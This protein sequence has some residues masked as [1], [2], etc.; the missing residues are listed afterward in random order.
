MLWLTSIVSSVGTAGIIAFIAFIFRKWITIRLSKSIQHEYDHKLAEISSELKKGEDELSDIRK[1]MMSGISTA[2]IALNDRR[3][4][5]ID[6]L[7]AGLLE[8]KKNSL[9]IRFL[10]SLNV[11]AIGDEINNPKAQD[12]V[13]VLAKSINLQEPKEMFS[14][15]SLKASTAQPWV[16]PEIWA[17]YTAYT[18]IIFYGI[19]VF[20]ALQNRIGTPK[21][22]LDVKSINESIQKALPELELDWNNLSEAIFPELLTLI[23]IKLLQEIETTISGKKS[24]FET[25]QRI[26]DMQEQL[27]QGN[28]IALQE[29]EQTAQKRNLK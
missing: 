21:K 9:P 13:D 25:Y 7:W 28:Q 14:E 24:D 19:T 20:I 23:E 29:E 11:D 16:G 17:L 22:L 3:L 8:A 18:S 2:Q 10:A 5:A 6:D 27:Q 15:S 12:F 1:T 26:Y 4:K